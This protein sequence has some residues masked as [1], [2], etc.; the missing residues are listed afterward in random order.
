[1]LVSPSNRPGNGLFLCQR[2]L[3]W[4]KNMFIDHLKTLY[5]VLLQHQF[6]M[7]TFFTALLSSFSF[8]KFYNYFL[9]EN[10]QRRITKNQSYPMKKAKR[11]CDLKEALVWWV[12]QP[13][14]KHI[15]FLRYIPLKT[16][17][18]VFLWCR[19]VAVTLQKL[20]YGWLLRFSVC[21]CRK[22]D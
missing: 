2:L 22:D 12:V 14:Q 18:I 3:H 10:A 15:K 1:M 4:L 20:M 16:V 21:R 19:S 13:F 8:C 17:L 6:S 7:L 5:S 9:R 11:I